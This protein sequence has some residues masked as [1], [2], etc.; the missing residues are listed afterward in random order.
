MLAAIL[1]V[2]ALMRFWGYSGFSF[3]NDELSALYRLRFDNFS[4]LVD[5]GFYVDG[6]PGGVQVFLWY[7]IKLFG[8][9]EA[10]LRFPFVISGILT[11]LF[12]YLIA[13]SW[14]GRASGLLVASSMAFLMFPILYSQV[15]RPYGSGLFLVMVMVF[16][17]THL[18][19]DI[20][21]APK[22]KFLYTIVFTIAVASCMYNHYFSFL[23]A[24]LVGLTGLI[25]VRGKDLIF[26]LGAGL[27]AV[28]LF[29]PHLY[30]TLNHLS[31]GGVGEWLGKPDPWWLISHIFF[32][33]NRSWLIIISIVI[34]VATYCISNKRLPTINKFV[35]ISFSWFLVPFLIGHFYSMFVNPVLQDPV[36][37]FSFPFL[38]FALFAAAGDNIRKPFQLILALFLVA[39][40]FSTVVE[41][42]YYR[43]Q[44]F[45]EF[46]DI[47]HSLAKWQRIYGAD[48]LTVAVSVNNPFYL[49][50]YLQKENCHISYA[51]ADCK[52]REGLIDLGKVLQTSR[53]SYFVYAWTKPVSSLTSD[54]IRANY[55]YVIREKN[56]EG[57]SEVTL[58]SK[59][60]PVKT[61]M[62]ELPYQTHTEYYNIADL[63]SEFQSH[64]DSSIYYSSPSSV[65]LDSL[66]EFGP[67]YVNSLESIGT[68][69]LVRA[70]ILT[71][72]TSGLNGAQ[73][74]ISLETKEGKSIQWESSE[75]D[76]FA[77][78]SNWFKVIH[79]M[80]LPPNVSKDAILKIYVWNPGRK[81][82][83]M[84]DLKV[85]LFHE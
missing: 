4:D 10:S 60:K 27:T 76:M 19:F 38:L 40:I 20:D 67:G 75:F 52:G 63:P 56:Y 26:Y 6:H 81:Q 72:A 54:L 42:K 80:Q 49:D 18:V 16:S 17:W 23:M 12:S 68:P 39:G 57:F 51:L 84:D 31:I 28:I 83:N 29:L 65:K 22:K 78:S 2:A 9:S 58:Y 13:R 53:T 34:L 55:P 73:L 45:G 8:T 5:K 47:A 41:K 1:A 43:S 14:F 30:I 33:F 71:Y 36:L 61:L 48:S 69:S 50:Y 85:E 32:I 46:K 79:T 44:H 37:I 7:W 70:R 3:S 66:I 11:V 82:V 77:G 74:V 25:Y 15:A 35:A 62:T 24:I 21:I 64:A 59:E